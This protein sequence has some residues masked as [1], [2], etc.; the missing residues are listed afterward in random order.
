MSNTNYTEENFKK[1]N[2]L[3]AKFFED[4]EARD[5][6]QSEIQKTT[7]CMVIGRI[8][9]NLPKKNHEEFMILF[10]ENPNDG[11]KLSNYLREN[12]ID[13]KINDLLS[14]ISQELI[15]DLTPDKE[16]TTETGY[17]GKVPIK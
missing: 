5:E 11:D 7:D 14:E 12:K 6:A 10:T 4:R 9:D 3:V 2:D 16:I 8:L 13:D 1:V 17:E 15:G